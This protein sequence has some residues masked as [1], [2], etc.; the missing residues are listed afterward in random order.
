VWDSF[1]GRRRYIYSR[2]SWRLPGAPK[3]R[4]SGLQGTRQLPHV[5]IE[6]Y[7]GERVERD[8]VMEFRLVYIGELKG[9][10]RTDSR[11]TMKHSIRR[12]FHPQLRQLWHTS[13]TLRQLATRVA[14]W[15]PDAGDSDDI[16]PALQVEEE[17]SAPS[18]F[19]V[20]LTRI[21]EQWQ[22]SGCRF[23]PLVTAA[24]CLRCSIDILFL[25]PEDPGLLIKSG[26]LDAR[27]KTVF[28][29]LRMPVNLDEMGGTSPSDDENPFFVLLEDDKLISEVRITTD[30]LL[31]LPH[32]RVLRPN[33]AF[34]V[35]HVRLQPTR[36]VLHGWVFA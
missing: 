24:L 1:A 20:G 23:V 5:E 36:P 3:V 15:G 19:D 10:S 21:A 9:A 2:T 7:T 18:A 14:L 30:K 35:I 17:I 16:N 11:A 27:V 33:D 32:E 12:E 26:D 31:L 29:A 34:L 22:R 28:D 6:R 25:R 4:K 8:N 13:S